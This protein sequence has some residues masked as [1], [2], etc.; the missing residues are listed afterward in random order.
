VKTVC[1]NACPIAIDIGLAS[2]SAEPPAAYGTTIFI[3]L[4]GKFCALNSNESKKI[5][6]VTDQ[7]E[8]FFCMVYLL[9]KIIYS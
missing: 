2:I 1:P 9:L 8:N 4:L 7:I 3:G 6:T 5:K